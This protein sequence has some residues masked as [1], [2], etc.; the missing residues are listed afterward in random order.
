MTCRI[1]TQP[2]SQ[3][4][5]SEPSFLGDIKNVCRSQTNRLCPFPLFSSPE[6]P[7]RRVIWSLSGRESCEQTTTTK[8]KL[9]KSA[10]YRI[11]FVEGTERL[12]LFL[13]TT[14]CI[15]IEI[16]HKFK[17]QHWTASLLFIEFEYRKSPPKIVIQFCHGILKSQKLSFFFCC[18]FICS[19]TRPSRLLN[20]KLCL[21][22]Q[23][24]SGTSIAIMWCSTTAQ[25][26]PLSQFSFPSFYLS[27]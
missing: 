23:L 10:E 9:I 3:S 22:L 19:L 7:L 1:H 4:M 15:G 2:A 12:I 26:A 11:S 18:R 17:S 6:N 21:L 27:A 13:S 24:R 16:R 20:I 8:N 25:G 5:P 14:T